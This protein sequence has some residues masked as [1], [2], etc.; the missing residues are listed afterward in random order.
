[1]LINFHW[2]QQWKGLCS[3]ELEK[4]CSM[5]IRQLAHYC[6]IIRVY[7]FPNQTLCLK[8]CIW[9]ATLLIVRRVIIIKM[10]IF[11]FLVVA[12][13]ANNVQGIEFADIFE[14]EYLLNVA[15]TTMIHRQ[16]G[17]QKLDPVIFCLVFCIQKSA[18][19]WRTWKELVQ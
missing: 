13:F 16:C 8:Q 18:Q 11:L 4:T 5:Q 15:K 10:H 9:I 7:F 2:A 12:A 17:Y 1:M 19:I 3:R 14:V 6:L